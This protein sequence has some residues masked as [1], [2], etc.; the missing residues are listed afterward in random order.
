M[1]TSDAVGELLAKMAEERE[2]LLGV[3][4]TITPE[5]AEYQPPDK[6]GEEGWSVKEQLVHLAQMDV[7]YRRWCTRT[8]REENPDLDEPD[9]TGAG[10][11]V[12]PARF[13]LEVAH[14]VELPE[15]VAEMDRQRAR[16]LEYIGGLSVDDLE[17]RSH[18]RLFGELSLIQWLRSYYRH[19]RMHTA[20]I[21]GRPSEYQPRFQTGEPDG[22]RRR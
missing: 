4:R 11:S 10:A 19:D 21:Q 15:L 22:R 16:T 14:E 1:T 3:V 6:D 12:E 13:T 18:N 17:R 9:T 7:T 2:A 8:V 20:Q 5:V